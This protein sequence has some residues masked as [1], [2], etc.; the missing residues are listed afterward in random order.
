MVLCGRFPH[1]CQKCGFFCGSTGQYKGLTVPDKLTTKERGLW[2]G[3]QQGMEYNENF[4]FM[5]DEEID[6]I[7]GF[8]KVLELLQKLP[9]KYVT[10]LDV[11]RYKAVAQ[12]VEQIAQ[13]MQKSAGRCSV[14]SEES[15]MYSKGINIHI[16]ADTITV[17]DIKAFCAALSPASCLDVQPISGDMFSID[18]KFDNILKATFS[19]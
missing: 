2:H 6:Q 5:T 19:L 16:V 3:S 13:I 11:A 4:D 12:A 15:G 18:I 1:S 17:S 14:D 7:T 10:V 8:D 9:E